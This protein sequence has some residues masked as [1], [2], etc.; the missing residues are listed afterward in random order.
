MKECKIVFDIDGTICNNS[1]GKYESA[2]PY[3][4]MVNFINE[5]YDKGYT[6]IF[7]SARGF[8]TFNGDLQKINEKWYDFTSNQLKSWGVKF[9]YLVLGKP[10]GKA[11]IDDRGFKVSDDGS[12]VEKIRELLG[13]L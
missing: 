11:Y 1:Y 10:E 8:G 12:D 6:I 4:K 9:H 2:T 5:L 7:H 13:E 3:I